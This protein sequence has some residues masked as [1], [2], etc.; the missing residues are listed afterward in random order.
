MKRIIGV[1]FT[2]KHYSYLQMIYML[3][4]FFTES[5]IYKVIYSLSDCI[6]SMSSCAHAIL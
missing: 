4:A 3:S 5:N 2:N 6:M 1:F